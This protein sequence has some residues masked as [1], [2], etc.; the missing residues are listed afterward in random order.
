MD[1]FCTLLDFLISCWEENDCDILDLMFWVKSRKSFVLIMVKVEFCHDCDDY[2]NFWLADKPDLPTRCLL[3]ICFFNAVTAQSQLF[4][5]SSAAAIALSCHYYLI[6]PQHA[7]SSYVSPPPPVA[8][9]PI[10]LLHCN[11]SVMPVL[12]LYIFCSFL[13]PQLASPIGIP[14]PHK[15]HADI[16]N[17]INPPVHTDHKESNS[18]PTENHTL[19]TVPSVFTLTKGKCQGIGCPGLHSIPHT[20]LAVCGDDESIQQVL[21]FCYERMIAKSKKPRDLHTNVVFYMFACE[22][23]F[24]KVDSMSCLHWRDDARVKSYLDII[25]QW[26]TQDQGGIMHEYVEYQGTQSKSINSKWCIIRHHILTAK[27]KA[28]PIGEVDLKQE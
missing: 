12:L 26:P 14:N 6:L 20:P 4:I 17:T 15:F 3:V 18:P 28:R 11:C 7:S 23:K 16:N 13:H 27:C 10:F 1:I 24:E 22:D 5:F 21:C 9:L 25:L 19:P 2:L 8:A